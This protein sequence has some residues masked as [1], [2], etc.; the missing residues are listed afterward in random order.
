LGVPGRAEV[1]DELHLAITKGVSPV[2]GGAFARGTLKV[3]LA[4]LESSRTRKEVELRVAGGGTAK[5]K[6]NGVEHG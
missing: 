4:I 6:N 1:L 3:C 2:H 5:P